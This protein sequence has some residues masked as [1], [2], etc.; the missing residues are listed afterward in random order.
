VLIFERILNQRM[1]RRFLAV[2]VRQTLN[3]RVALKRNTQVNSV[4]LYTSLAIVCLQPVT[5]STCRW[6]ATRCS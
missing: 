1:R 4:L 5:C 2:G 6:W 3:V